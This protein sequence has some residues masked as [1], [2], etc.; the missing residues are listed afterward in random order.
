VALPDTEVV[1]GWLLRCVT[2]VGPLEAIA[3]AA[4]AADPA[5]TAAAAAAVNK[6]LFMGI[7]PVSPEAVCP[8]VWW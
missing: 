8:G 7:P 4:A 5:S 2:E 3:G 1:S 6:I